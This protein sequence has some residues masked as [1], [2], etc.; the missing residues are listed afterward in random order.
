[1]LFSRTFIVVIALFIAISFAVV[2][3]VTAAVPGPYMDEIFHIPQARRYIV[4]GDF[5]TYDPMLTTPPGLYLL[6]TLLVLVP[7]VSRESLAVATVWWLRVF[8][9]VGVGGALLVVLMLLKRK[10]NGNIYLALTTVT[11]PVGIFSS[12][13]FYSDTLSALTT[14]ITLVISHRLATEK[15]SKSQRM[16][17]ILLLVVSNIFSLLVRQT[18]V[19]WIF[20]WICSSRLW[21]AQRR[22]GPRAGA[23]GPRVP[24]PRQAC[25]DELFNT[26]QH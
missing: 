24:W 17:M 26:V 15:K 23:T 16:M 8:N 22:C 14:V 13:L 10:R 6:S 7:G 5:A 11:L 4:D 3:Y 12:W 9:A 18:N 25:H 1:M 21:Q 2:N 19:V 20:F